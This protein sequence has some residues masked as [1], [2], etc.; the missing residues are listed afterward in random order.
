MTRVPRL[1][2]A[3]YAICVL[4]VPAA[5]MATGR[6]QLVDLG[7]LAMILL[8]GPLG[9]LSGAGGVRGRPCWRW[10]ALAPLVTLAVAACAL[11]VA[12]A[13]GL[14]R[15]Q[16]PAPGLGVPLA[17]AGVSAL[18]SLLE[19]WGWAGAG[20]TLAVD[21]FGRRYG[22]VA[23]GLVW[24]VWH[25]IPVVL[26]VGMFPDL[27]AGPPVRLA[28]FVL[29]CVAYRELLTRLQARAETWVA[30]ALA[31]AGPN[32]LVAALM[33]AGA[34]GFHVPDDWALYPAP[35]GIVFLG[36]VTAAVFLVGG[37]RRGVT[38]RG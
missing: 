29:A 12:A 9:M 33:A 24:A 13:A 10:V 19:E 14:V 8:P 3:A 31:H 23:L 30:A 38:V 25:L 32:A 6:P 27:E 18:T 4:A 20:L 37:G 36:L 7:R 11:A 1:R 26:R 34:S 17:A 16:G 35:G 22:V 5:L 21:A 28:V 2:F 15:Q